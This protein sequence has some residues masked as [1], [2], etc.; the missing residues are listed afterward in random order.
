M[1]SVRGSRESGWLFLRLRV[2]D[3]GI[4]GS[5]YDGGSQRAYCVGRSMGQIYIP[6][7]VSRRSTSSLWEAA[8]PQDFA[9][10]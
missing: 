1:Y 5:T 8:L 3:V 10:P 7:T 4:V 2:Q 6:G 9:F